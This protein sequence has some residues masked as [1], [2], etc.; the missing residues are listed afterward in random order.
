MTPEEQAAWPVQGFSALNV[1]TSLGVAVRK[2]TGVMEGSL[3]AEI[4]AV[5]VPSTMGGSNT[6]GWGYFGQGEAVIPAQVRFVE[7]PYTAGE[8]AALGKI[9]QALGTTPIDVYLNDRAY[10]GNVLP[11][12]WCYKSAATKSSRIG[13]PTMNTACWTGR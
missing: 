8:L 10:L 4:A 7:R 9:V 13:C 5:A 2:F 3:G 1:Y 11:A 6:A 12:V